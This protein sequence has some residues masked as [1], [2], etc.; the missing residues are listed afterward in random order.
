MTDFCDYCVLAD[1]GDT[2][3]CW[4]TITL[5]EE[6]EM[7]NGDR[8]SISACSGHRGIAQHGCYLEEGAPVPPETVGVPEELVS[9]WESV[10]SELSLSEDL[11]DYI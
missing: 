5:I 10:P 11:T 4:G 7:P 3:P 8:V 1:R 9:L 2:P 6:I